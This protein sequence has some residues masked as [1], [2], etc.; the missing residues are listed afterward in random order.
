LAIDGE[1]ETA[2]TSESLWL[3]SRFQTSMTWVRY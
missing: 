2:G 3:T 1:G